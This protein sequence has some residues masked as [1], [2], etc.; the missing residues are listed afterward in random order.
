MIDPAVLV[1]DEQVVAGVR[2]RMGR[3]VDPARN[4]HHVHVRIRDEEAVN[5]V[6][7][8]HVERHLASGGNL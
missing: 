6:G 7:T 1:A 2:E 4:R 3:L 5:D 8:R